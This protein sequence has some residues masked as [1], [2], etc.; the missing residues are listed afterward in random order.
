MYMKSKSLIISAFTAMAALSACTEDESILGS[1]GN[2]LD[3]SASIPALTRAAIEGT[4]LPENAQLGVS[5]FNPD[6]SD[7]DGK[8]QGYKNVLYK[9]EI[10]TTGGGKMEQCKSHY[11]IAFKG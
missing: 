7:Y 10:L 1:N 9:S 11:P 8:Q 3:V 6:G 5:L 4:Q 2:R